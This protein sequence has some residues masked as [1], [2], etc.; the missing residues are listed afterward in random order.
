M[1]VACKL[2]LGLALLQGVAYAQA[3][4]I[5]VVDGKISMSAQAVPL[6]RLLTLFG[7][8]VGMEAKVK[9]GLENRNVSVMFTDLKFN[10]AI[11]KIFEG[12]NLNY[13][14]VQGKAITVTE[15]ADTSGTAS[16]AT[17]SP[18]FS[19][20]PAFTPAVTNQPIPVQPLPVT[21]P[22]GG[23]APA[24]TNTNTSP[25]PVSGPGMAPP[26]IGA[27][28]PLINP[29]GGGAPNPAGGGAAN[30]FGGGNTP[31]SPSQPS[32]PGAVPGTPGAMPGTIR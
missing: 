2:L 18:S 27:S 15:L 3:P 5:D 30:P 9:P 29:V 17:S 19:S 4:Q 23:P 20:A 22:F 11:R 10:D 1:R 25:A 21:S 6:G 26:P 24:A 8:A 14:V 7:R 28:N 32:G 31:P 12:Q 13:V 16:T